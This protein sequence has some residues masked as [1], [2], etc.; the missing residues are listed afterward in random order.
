[1]VMKYLPRNHRHAKGSLL[2]TS[3][4]MSRLVLFRFIGSFSF[5]TSL[6]HGTL[7]FPF[8]PAG[9]C[10][11]I[12]EN[13]RTFV[14]QIASLGSEEG[15]V[16]GFEEGF[17]LKLRDS[18]TSTTLIHIKVLSEMSQTPS[19]VSATEEGICLICRNFYFMA[20]ARPEDVLS[21]LEGAL[22]PSWSDQ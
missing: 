13:P 14:M 9:E 10:L 12:H 17:S 4:D 5:A 22:A 18:D 7:L 6:R 1:M 20:V 19:S 8:E 15:V 16:L 2:L 3:V 11:L 21:I